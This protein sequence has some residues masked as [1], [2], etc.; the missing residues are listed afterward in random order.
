M[1][2]YY[3]PAT[4]DFDTLAPT[5]TKG[6][7]IVHDGT[8]NVRLGVGT[9][10]FVLTADSVQATGVKWAAAGAASADTYGRKLLVMGA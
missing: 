6:D 1:A 8:D 2:P 9:N 10:A 3:P 5:T 7:L 4:A